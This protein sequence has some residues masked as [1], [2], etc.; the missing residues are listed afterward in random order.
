MC[1]RD[2]VSTVAP[3]VVSPD[4]VSKKASVKD[5]PGI[6]IIKGKVAMAAIITQASVTS[7]KPSRACNS[8][9]N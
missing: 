8:R 2:R 1:I 9:V 3:V 7:K 4:I 6:A 5:R